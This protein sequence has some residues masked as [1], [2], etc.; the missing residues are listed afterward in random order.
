MNTIRES[1]NTL[2]SSTNSSPSSNSFDIDTSMNS[3]ASISNSNN[4][5]GGIKPK[6]PLRKDELEKIAK[7]LKKKL[8]KASITAKQSLSPTNL[9]ATPNSS[10][11]KASPLKYYMAKNKFGNTSSPSNSNN[12]SNVFFSSPH[13]YSPNGKSPT[14]MKTSSAA[15]F[16]SSS[17]LKGVPLSASD[18][19]LNRSNINRSNY[20]NNGHNHQDMELLDSPTKKRSIA[21]LP[22]ND[23][24]TTPNKLNSAK[25]QSPSNS[26]ITP[27]SLAT[28]LKP[29]P[30]LTSN[31]THS[32]S[33]SSSK[34]DKTN[35]KGDSHNN[36]KDSNTVSQQTTPTLTKRQLSG[37]SSYSNN[38]LKTP[39]QSRSNTNGG[40]GGNFNDEEGADLL[41]YLATSP[42]PAKPMGH[43]PRSKD[44]NSSIPTSAN[45][46]HSTISHK[47]PSS[48]GGSNGSINSSSINSTSNK[49]SNSNSFMVPPLTPKRHINSTLTRTP[50]NRLTPSI[51]FFNG[52]IN[53]NGSSGLPSSGLTLTPAGFN[54]SDYVFFTPS[55]GS[56][57]V[58]HH[59][60]NNN[61]GSSLGILNNKNFLKTPDF[62]SMINN[63][64]GSQ[65]SANQNLSVGS[66]QKNLNGNKN[67]NGNE[68]NGN[69]NGNKQIV[70][71]KMINF[72][73]VGLFGNPNENSSKD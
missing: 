50:Q 32:S 61:A 12:H 63:T 44:N 57:A 18:N 54:M 73:K 68:S 53:N 13:L 33:N 39:T 24:L 58:A 25:F 20:N 7:E 72:D 17:P 28:A 29:S 48:S 40:N 64:T 3:N 31:S 42:S 51:N 6:T 71:G 55:P 26:N 5:N 59:N 22:L 46:N 52:T 67:G 65:S 60:S 37:Q 16:L 4:S 62:N 38:L 15:L 2:N 47:P 19:K 36:N 1:N 14:Q 34:T 23:E 66:I 43:T 45:S 11:P 35:N 21:S 70:D 10:N 9:K 49:D 8:S 69:G 27:N 56:A 30:A 41:M